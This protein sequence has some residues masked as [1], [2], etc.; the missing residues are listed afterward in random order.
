MCLGENAPRIH[1][2]LLSPAAA[3]LV[4]QPSSGGGPLRCQPAHSPL[5]EAQRLLP[6]AHLLQQSPNVRLE[7]S[8]LDRGNDIIN[9]KITATEACNKCRII[10]T[11]FVCKLSSN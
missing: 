9:N 11:Q 8:L 10:W 7:H 5:H 4:I 2:L 3:E 1:P 6:S